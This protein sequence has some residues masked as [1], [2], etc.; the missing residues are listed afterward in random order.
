MGRAYA[1]GGF[2]EVAEDWKMERWSL[3]NRNRAALDDGT[4]VKCNTSADSP[5]NLDIR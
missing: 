4:P 5:I 3:G 1:T 2:I